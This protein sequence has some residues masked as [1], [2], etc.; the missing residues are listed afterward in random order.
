MSRILRARLLSAARTDALAECSSDAWMS[1]C[2]HCR[3][4]V[5]ITPDGEPLGSTTLEH[6][7]PRS[8]FDDRRAADLTG[9]LEGP[10]DPRNLALVCARCNHGK[11]KGPDLEGPG[12]TRAREIVGKLLE[13][14][15]ARFRPLGDA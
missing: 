6:V 13:R 5:A 9:R 15:L 7:V 1:R 3:A 11:G 12:S 2:L 4:R 14:R 8:W 10:D